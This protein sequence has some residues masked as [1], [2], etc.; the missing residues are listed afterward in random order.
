MEA[1]AIVT[2]SHVRR[3][4]MHGGRRGALNIRHSRIRGRATPP[5]SSV[6]PGGQPNFE[7]GPPTLSE[8]RG[9]GF[10]SC[11]SPFQVSVDDPTLVDPTRTPWRR[12]GC[13]CQTYSL[14][15]HGSVEPH[16]PKDPVV[17]TLHGGRTL[18]LKGFGPR[19]KPLPRPSKY[20]RK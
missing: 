9:S 16:G 12:T 17:R 20:L 14:G 6:T 10:H 4:A 13:S 7:H 19:V 8:V 18:K 1:F 5:P 3:G 2:C 11:G 15:R